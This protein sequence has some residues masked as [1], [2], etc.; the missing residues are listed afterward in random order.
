MPIIIAGPSFQSIT[1]TASARTFPPFSIRHDASAKT[2]ITRS[3]AHQ[4][5]AYTG[6]LLATIRHE[7]TVHPVAIQ[8]LTHDA[9]A[10][11][12]APTIPPPVIVRTGSKGRLTSVSS[13]KGSVVSAQYSHT[14]TR[15]SMT[16][17][18]AGATSPTASLDLTVFSSNDTGGESIFLS[19]DCDQFQYEVQ[20]TATGTN[21]LLKGE[22]KNAARL[23]IVRL[24]EMI[25]WKLN[26][27]PLPDRRI[28]CEARLPLQETDVPGIV[29]S[30]FKAAGMILSFIGRDPLEGAKWKEKER[31]Y[32]TFGK[33][34]DQVFNDAYGQLG[35]TYIV[36]G[37]RAFTTPQD[38]FLF[39]RNVPS[40]DLRID[41]TVRN[42]AQ[43]TP[44]LVNVTGAD[45]LINRPSLIALAVDAPD[46]ASLLREVS[47]DYDWYVTTPTDTG[48]TIKGFR[49]T[50]GQMAFTNELVRSSVTVQ[51]TVDGVLQS[52]TFN[53]VVTGY[54]STSSRYDPDCKD[55]L[56]YQQT[57][58]TSYGYALNTTTHSTIF[59]GPGWGGGY[60]AGDTL[61][62]ETQ[63]TYQTYS[64]EGYL[65]SRQTTTVKLASLQQTGADGALAS[66]GPLVAREYTTV[67][68]SETYQPLSGG[69]WLRVW[70]QSGGQQLPLYDT[71]SGDA[72]RLASRGGTLNNGQE[73]L[74]QAPSQ[75]T[76][77]DPC[78][79][80]KIS[81]PQVERRSMPDGREGAEVSRSL[82]FVTDRLL[83]ST[84][85]SGIARLLAPSTVTEFTLAGVMDLRPGVMLNGAVDGVSEGYSIDAGNGFAT[86]KV[87]ARK[88]K[89]VA[90]NSVPQVTGRG[91]FRDMVIWRLPGG[92][93][94]NHLKGF[95]NV[96]TPLFD[97]IFVRATGA[98]LPAPGDEL[99]W[100]DDVRFGPTA[101]GNYGS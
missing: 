7:A 72:V 95:D 5:R 73:Q 31:D 66:R 101:T 82:P 21:T 11:T 22:N 3:L 25:P 35:Y 83:L 80:K 79:T 78:G 65:Q 67:I 27:T 9:Y 20:T 12:N 37:D 52:R 86:V 42:E 84:Y 43:N 98:N 34:P 59:S 30:A 44:S 33:T 39:I 6:P 62:N 15:E 47:P 50:A 4:A 92:V 40:R 68:L 85:A 38:G 26:P 71:D 100:R 99:E 55:K 89:V 1:H 41:R 93:N 58:K 64:A 17:T 97:R 63:T 76:C 49:K 61:A 96:G 8:T 51:E 36:R 69:K 54:S 74:D 87:T 53:G 60:E 46:M 57:V 14:G 28:P 81:Y 13:S 10:R 94:V 24:D 2:F 91:P 56:T 77:P 75:V 29:A 88:L 48:E 19:L 32:S 70:S 16:M 23:G 90:A 45:L 18:V